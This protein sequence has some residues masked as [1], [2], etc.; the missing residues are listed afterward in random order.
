[1]LMSCKTVVSYG[2]SAREE[3][4]VRAC[5]FFFLEYSLHMYPSILRLGASC[6]GCN[7]KCRRLSAV[8]D[9]SP[10]FLLAT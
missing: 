3:E 10:R 5:R 6:Y 1:M 7:R 8:V 4:E 2:L 9:V